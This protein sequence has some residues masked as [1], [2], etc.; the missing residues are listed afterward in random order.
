MSLF[1][2]PFCT[3]MFIYLLYHKL[4]PTP[5][6]QFVLKRIRGSSESAI[7][8]RSKSISCAQLCERCAK[9]VRDMFVIPIFGIN[10]KCSI[11][12]KCCQEKHFSRLCRLELSSQLICSSVETS[13]ILKVFWN[14][15]SNELFPAL[16]I[17]KAKLIKILI[18]HSWLVDFIVYLLQAMLDATAVISITNLY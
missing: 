4:T 8:P 9:G 12:N 1:H 17:M 15:W 5:S 7:W 3:V 10:V 6:K 16:R 11:L 18:L 13:L 14:I 2:I